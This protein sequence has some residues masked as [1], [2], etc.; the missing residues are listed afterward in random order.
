MFTRVKVSLY[1]VYLS[2]SFSV[3]SELIWARTSFLKLNSQKAHLRHKLYLSHYQR[4]PPTY[5]LSYHVQ[6]HSSPSSF[7]L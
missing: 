2:A 1:Q 7:N 3:M 5:E 6:A 4:E